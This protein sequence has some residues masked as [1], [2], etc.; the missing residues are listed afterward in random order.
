MQVRFRKGIYFVKD[1]T[2][3]VWSDLGLSLR[4]VQFSKLYW[5]SG[6]KG[7]K[8][9]WNPIKVLKLGNKSKNLVISNQ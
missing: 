3:V 6:N 1:H 5:F 2:D 8:M 7:K 9:D 4:D